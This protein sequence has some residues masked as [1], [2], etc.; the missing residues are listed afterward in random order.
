MSSDIT[1]SANASGII[2]ADLVAFFARH[3]GRA[4]IVLISAG[5]AGYGV[6][7]LIPPTYTSRVVVIPPRAAGDGLTTALGSLSALASFAGA[8][9]LA[10]RTTAD[11]TLS[12]LNTNAVL[13]PIVRKFE[14]VAVYRVPML[15]DARKKLTANTNAVLGKRD[16]LIYVEVEDEDPARA[17]DIANEYVEQL[18]RVTSELALSEAQQRRAFF[19]EHLKA[20]RDNL[21]RA[22]AALQAV[23]VSADVIKTEPRAAAESVARLGAEIL[24]AEVTLQS[25]RTRLQPAASEV[26]AAVTRIS[27]LRSQLARLETTA[28]AGQPD[29][30]DYIT[31]YRDFKYQETL[32]EL[33]ARQYESARIDESRDGA[34]MQ[35]VDKAVPAERRTRP[36]RSLIALAIAIAGC[37]VY[38][39]V[40]WLQRPVF[41]A[42]SGGASAE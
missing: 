5:A 15:T 13:D 17:A 12:L 41:R 30:A 32:F 40:A 11:T 6:A 21:T 25:L 14:L 8:G 2:P 42:P 23:G 16:G 1:P 22:Q 35:V 19:A 24:S 39:A 20:A 10:G 3:W 28:K 33:F 31:L 27:A 9:A 26:T 38:L 18:R 29:R 4:L 34:L 7:W 37:S 36:I